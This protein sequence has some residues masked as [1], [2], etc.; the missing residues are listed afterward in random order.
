VFWDIPSLPP[1]NLRGEF[2]EKS[3][4]LAWERPQ[5]VAGETTPEDVVGYNLYR[6]FPGT[7]FPF[8]PANSEL[9]TTL[10]CRDSGIDADKDYLYTLRAVRKVRESFVESENSEE[11]TINT[12]DR[13]P[14]SPPQ[15][16]AAIPTFTGVLL[17]WKENEEPD[18]KGYN[19][20]RKRK[21][22]T[23]FKKVNT[24]LLTQANYLD[25]EAEGETSYIY[26]VTATDDSSSANES[27][28]S[29]EVH[30]YYHY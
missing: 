26:V 29:Q 6:T 8:S 21:D 27:E 24:A 15:D 3:V 4:V 18:I 13:T 1:R 25:R 5:S 17:K 28:R 19:L 2:K 10:A 20:Y 30:I 16:L 7:P 14:P 11:I 23:H 22:D 9:I 12:T